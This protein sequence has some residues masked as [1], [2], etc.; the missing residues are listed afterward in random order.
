MSNTGR[1]PQRLP[2][3]WRDPAPL[4]AALAERWGAEG[5][6]WL[7]GD[8]TRLG[9]WLT[10]AVDPVEQTSCRG[11]PG[12]P[13]STDPFALLDQ[14]GPGHWCGWLSYE[15]AAWVEPAEHWRRDSMAS[16]WIARHD[17]LLR[18]DLEHRQ[19]WLEG[20][21]P[22]RLQ[23]MARWLE[24]L[25]PQESAASAAPPPRL[26]RKSTR[27]NSSHAITSRMP[28]SA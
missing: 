27:L 5:L 9:R 25:P 26:D 14:L 3:P 6:I 18:F 7:D 15:A 19:L 22:G 10:L 16:L 4:A 17:P 11:L 2:L 28:S 8:G 1:P 20:W 13:G 12:D 23:A 24:A 21:D